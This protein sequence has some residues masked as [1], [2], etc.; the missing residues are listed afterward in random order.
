MRT[1]RV[2]GAT[3]VAVVLTAALGVV[4]FVGF[5]AVAASAHNFLVSSTP[6]SGSTLTTLPAEFSVTT[7]DNLIMLGNAANSGAIEITGPDGL[8][9]GD[10]CVSI[11]GPTISTAAALG[12]PGE[13]TLAW[14]VVSTDGH[15]VTN[16]FSFSWAPDGDQPTS[17][18]SA[19][20]PLCPGSDAAAAAQDAGA[21]AQDAG[22]AGS[23]LA[24]GDSGPDTTALWIGG[25]IAVIAVAVI[26]TLIAMRRKPSDRATP[27]SPGGSGGS[28]GDAD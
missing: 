4:G 22:A 13:Y 24:A 7:N 19:T 2:L 10:G 28:G 15:P 20:V 11:A 6:E 25:A 8:Y 27:G 17:T 23:D 12:G 14:R 16:E 3:R 9:Y 5:G 1:H 18:G 21:A 26:A